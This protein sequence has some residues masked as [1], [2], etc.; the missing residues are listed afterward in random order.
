[1]EKSAQASAVPEEF[2]AN[3]WLVEEM[4]EQYQKDPASV[5][6]AWATFFKNGNGTSNGSSNG[7]TASTTPAAPP[8]A[9]PAP[10]APAPAKPAA[11]APAP[12]P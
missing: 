12:T 4:Y 10:A 1:M 5:D 9:K 2:G 3:E 6:A 8:A 11:K 7:T